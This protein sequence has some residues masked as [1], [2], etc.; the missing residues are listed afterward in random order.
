[1]PV[2]STGPSLASR[3]TNWQNNSAGQF[4]ADDARFFAGSGATGGADPDDRVVYDTDSG[5]L[6]Y[7]ADG[8]GSAEAQLIAT[9]VTFGTPF[10]AS[11][12][13]VI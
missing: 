13:T 12:I 5:R 9:L 7:D 10:G 1:M 11:D 3:V 2:I 4:S 6:Y 8:S